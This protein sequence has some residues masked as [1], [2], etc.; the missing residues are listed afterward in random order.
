MNVL[1]LNT[2]SSSLKFQVID[3]DLDAIERNADRQLARGVIE[4]IGSESLVTFRVEGKPAVRRT[5]A[6]RD[7]RAALDYVLRWL[8]SPEAAVPGIASVGD[9]HAVGHRT[10]H[11]GEKFTRSVTISDE[12][13]DQIEDCIDL[14]PL[15]N[16]ANLKGIYAARELLGLGVPQVAVFDTSFHSTMPEVSYLYAIPYPLYVRH[17]IRRYGFHGTSHRYVAYRYRMLTGKSYDETNIVTVH[18]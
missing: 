12:V 9:I 3:T 10:V 16:P 8:V 13:V 4:R 1:V 11:G 14:A 7:H 18:L 2:G 5:A 6:L 15:H 17:K